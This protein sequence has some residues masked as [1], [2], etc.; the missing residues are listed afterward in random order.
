MR[1]GVQALKR[2]LENSGDGSLRPASVRDL[3]RAEKAG[4]PRELLAFYKIGGPDPRKGYV[5]LEQRI[6]SIGRALEENH[7][8]LPSD[9]DLS[10][11]FVIFA[12][13]PA[14]D[15][16]CVDT[17][18]TTERKLHP[19]VWLRHEVISHSSDILDLWHARIEVASSV[20]DFLLKISARTL[21]QT[22]S[23]ALH[24]DTTLTAEE[25]EGQ[26][27]RSGIQALKWA[28]KHARGQ[29]GR[30][31]PAKSKDL[32]RARKAGFPR[33]LIAFYSKYEP[34]PA[35]RYIEL[36][37]RLYSITVA[38]RENRASIPGEFV[39]PH[40]YVVFAGTTSGDGYCMDT[41]VR[42]KGGKHPIVLFAHDNF[43]RFS[44]LP[45]IQ[46][47]R[48]EVASS[49]DNFLLKFSTGQ[50]SEEGKY[51]LDGEVPRK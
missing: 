22:P 37:Q 5:E 40:G 2:A 47:S 24:P 11:G 46:A 31:R 20:E 4:F 12:V 48:V 1:N 18:V 35:D 13:N 43:E 41:N 15:A 36:D 49:L 29:A 42:S 51:F 3:R 9:T 33:E 23:P 44:D 30:I 17:N 26:A 8:T 19:V 16:Y 38:L 45:F 28:L 50:L 6:Y 27:K 7:K 10:H 14:G 21:H 25:L 32:D 34:H 39:F